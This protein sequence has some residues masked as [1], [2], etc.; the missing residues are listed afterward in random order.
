MNIKFKMPKFGRE[1]TGS[2]MLKELLLTTIA[3]TISIVLTFG[4]ARFIEHRQAQKAQRQTAMMLIHDIDESVAV[5][6]SMAE[7]EEKQKSALQYVIDHYDQIDSLPEDT[8]FTALTMLVDFYREEN[9]FD[10][11][12]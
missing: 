6:E 5:V 9:Y 3:T 1:L 2:T 11:S 4:T 10:D 8:L 7:N 12:K